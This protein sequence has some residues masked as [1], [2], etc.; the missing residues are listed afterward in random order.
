MTEDNAVGTHEFMDY[1]ELVGAEAYARATSATLRRSRWPGW[2][3]R[4]LTS[5]SG[6]QPRQGTRRQRPQGAVEAA[7]VDRQRAVGLR[8][9]RAPEYAADVT[10]RYGT[11][12]KVPQGQRIMKIASGA[13]GDDYNWTKVMMRDAGGSFDG[14]GVHYYT[15]PYDWNRKGQGDRVRQ[16][17]MGAHAGQDAQDG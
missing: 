2:D 10:R 9:Q 11:F 17:P 16:G 5:P 12:V 4:S 3:S 15:I 6:S 7:D 14:I 1:S 8:R 13:N